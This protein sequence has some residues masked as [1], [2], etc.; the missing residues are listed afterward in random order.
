MSVS[1][2]HNSII[3]IDVVPMLNMTFKSGL[4]CSGKS[5]FI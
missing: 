1:A 5:G 2:C 4:P 3:N